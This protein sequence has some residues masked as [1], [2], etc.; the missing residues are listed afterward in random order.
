MASPS[1]GRLLDADFGRRGP[2]SNTAAAY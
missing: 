1:N 2:K